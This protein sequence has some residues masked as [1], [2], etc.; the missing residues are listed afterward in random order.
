MRVDGPHL[1]LVEE[2]DANGDG[3]VSST[4]EAFA[5]LLLW[6]DANRNG[7]SDPLELEPI[8]QSRVVALSTEPRESQRKDRFGNRYRY[9]AIVYYADGQQRFA[10]DVFPLVEPIF[11]L[12]PQSPLACTKGRPAAIN[13][14]VAQR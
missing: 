14:G 8:T 6:F 3:I 10:Y 11:R 2:F 12:S 9:R 5:R 4:D 13:S 7:E 1:K